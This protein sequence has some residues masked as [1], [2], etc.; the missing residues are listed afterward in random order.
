MVLAAQPAPLTSSGMSRII[1]VPSVALLE[2]TMEAPN[3]STVLLSAPTASMSL[4]ALAVKLAWSCSLVLA[5]H[6]V[7]LA[8]STS[9][10]NVLLAATS[11]T[12]AKEVP[13][14]VSLANKDLSTSKENASLI[15][16]TELTTA[17]EVASL[18]PR[19]A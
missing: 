12:N 9:A 10:E 13:R 17:M 4:S 15:A 7:H 14:A 8:L 2:N 16:P 5:G 18:V 19:N 1:C 6:P 3:V 11:A